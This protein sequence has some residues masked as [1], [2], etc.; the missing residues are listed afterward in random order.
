MKFIKAFLGLLILPFNL[1]F[2]NP[3]SVFKNK[4]VAIIG[5]ADSAF[6]KKNGKYINEFDIVIRINKAV[7]NWNEKNEEY[8]GTK[9]D[10]L[11]HNFYE[12]EHSGG[13]KLDFS[14]F[15]SR[16]INYVV[17]PNSDFSG[18][19]LNYNF[20]KK[21]LK[22]NRTFILQPSLYKKMIQPFGD[23]KPT[24]G[25]ASLW[26]A[27]NAPCKEVFITGFTFFKTPYSIGY[28]D[29]LV[30]MKANKKHLKDQGIHDPNLEYQEFLKLINSIPSSKIHFDKQLQMIVEGSRNE[31]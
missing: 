23:L 8:L 3:L 22:W 21:Y 29:H 25:Y 12:N 14:L 19:R 28:R 7:V 17:N 13:G 6:E 4:R 30:D 1:R 5:A 20:Y 11:F 18:I 31:E 24:M 26:C 10:V 2:F 27:L 9:T 16:G 15:D